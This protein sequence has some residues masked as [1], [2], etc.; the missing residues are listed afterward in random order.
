MEV[1]YAGSYDTEEIR[2]FGAVGLF[3][4]GRE[5]NLALANFWGSPH[6]SRIEPSHSLN[7]F[8]SETAINWR[9]LPH[10]KNRRSVKDLLEH[11]TG[12]RWEMVG[13][14]GIAELFQNSPGL[15]GSRYQVFFDPFS[16]LSAQDS[17]IRDLKGRENSSGRNLTTFVILP[18]KNPQFSRQ[19]GS[20]NWNTSELDGS[21][22]TP[23]AR[24]P[25]E[26]SAHNFVKYIE[27]A[28]PFSKGV[29]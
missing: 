24:L 1:G 11:S 5:N 18:D 27:E 6:K 7:R 12:V 20:D 3:W 16:R 9:L 23:A 2:G 21:D 19:G 14:G 29:I 22:L 25:L 4:K 28:N 17:I 26:V 15:V 8:S 10:L 13:V